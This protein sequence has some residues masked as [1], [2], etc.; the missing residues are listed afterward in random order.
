M[1]YKSN[2]MQKRIQ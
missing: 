1:K 2:I